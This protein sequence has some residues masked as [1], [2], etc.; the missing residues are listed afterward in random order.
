MRSPRVGL[1]RLTKK[2]QLASEFTP[3]RPS[4]GYYNDLRGV[5]GPSPSAAL[6]R[7][8]A[9]RRDPARVNHVSIVQLGLGAWQHASADERWTGVLREV[10]DGVVD[11]LSGDALLEY[12]FPMPH[13]YRLDPPWVSAMAQGQAASL[14]LR[15]AELLSRPGLVDAAFLALE[16]LV[17]GTP[18]LVVRTAAGP[19]LQEYPT[20]PPAHVLNGWIFGLFGLYDAGATEEGSERGRAARAAFDEGAAAVAARLPLY[21]LARG[22]SRYDLF[23]HPLANVASPF[24]HRLHVELLR[25]LGRL[26]PHMRI[27]QTQARWAASAEATL[28]T[29]LAVVRK[30]AFRALRPRRRV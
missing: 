25:S 19:V 22:W 10:V 12:R 28:P 24:Y 7:L 29:A 15:S 20:E 2:P 3:G 5:A 21:E 26:R 17:R 11:E 1:L 14:L 23:P 27:A 9:L 4:S 16:P 8:R 13:T 18:P 30:A 6:E